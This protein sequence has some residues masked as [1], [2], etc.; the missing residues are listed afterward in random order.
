MATVTA[1]VTYAGQS[2]G[3]VVWDLMS[4]TT[5]VQHQVVTTEQSPIV[6]NNVQGGTYTVVG[7][8]KTNADGTGPTIG[9][10]ITSNPFVIAIVHAPATV[11]VVVT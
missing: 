8:G 2:C 7:T 4:G 10:P 6:F 1:N 9:N 11:T 5:Q 3:S